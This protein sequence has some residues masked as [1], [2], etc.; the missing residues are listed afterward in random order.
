MQVESKLRRPEIAPG[1]GPG[2]IV[3]LDGVTYEFKPTANDERHT[4]NV[5]NQAH[6]ARFL[7]IPEG[8][9]LAN[10]EDEDLV[11]DTEE[12]SLK[13]VDSP[14]KDLPQSGDDTEDDAVVQA[15]LEADDTLLEPGG[16]A[17][18]QDIA[19]KKAEAEL[20]AVLA[21]DKAKA[22]SD[23]TND[24]ERADVADT[25]PA[26]APALVVKSTPRKRGRPPVASKQ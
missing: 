25:S 11:E 4:C 14:V 18:S 23:V 5:R 16:Y 24:E 1:K 26:P 15:A 21:A 2:T 17:E 7:S 9:R 6:L 10:A 22:E 3:K 12:S 13:P 19:D 20:D 8:Y